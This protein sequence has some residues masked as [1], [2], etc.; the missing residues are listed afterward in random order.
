M[1]MKLDE[2]LQRQVDMARPRLCVKKEIA[3]L[4]A[5]LV[6]VG[7]EIERLELEKAEAEEN[8][9]NVLSGLASGCGDVSATCDAYGDAEKI[10]KESVAAHERW[11]MEYEPAKKRYDEALARIKAAKNDPSVLM[12]EPTPRNPD[13][14]LPEPKIK[15]IPQELASA[16]AS[17]YDKVER[18]TVHIQKAVLSWSMFLDVLKLRGLNVRRYWRR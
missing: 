14:N 17:F 3:K 4:V 5:A 18:E 12:H 9:G 7:G 13:K 15:D 1:S 10:H 16:Y 8:T 2:D 11:R 6:R